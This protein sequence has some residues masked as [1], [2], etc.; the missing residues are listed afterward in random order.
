MREM[1]SVDELQALLEQSHDEGVFIFKHSTRCPISGAAH[2]RV[3]AW[4][5]SKGEAAPR[6]F[7]VKVIEARPLSNAIADRLHI[8]HQSPQMI[9]VR[10]GLPLWDASH[11]GIT[12]NA[13]DNAL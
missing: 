11:G 12:A 7:L 6:V 13:L 8:P 9:L 4:L 1:T 5:K 3:V 10:N 2:D